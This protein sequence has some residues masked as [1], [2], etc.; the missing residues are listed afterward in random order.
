MKKEQKKGIDIFIFE[1]LCWIP[2]TNI[3][4]WINAVAQSLSRFRLFATPW[5]IQSLEFSRP[6]YWSGEPCPQGSS[7]PR[8]RTQVSH[9]A[10]G[11]FTSW[12]QGSPINQL[13]FNLKKSTGNTWLISLPH[14]ASP[15]VSAPVVLER[16]LVV[17]EVFCSLGP[18]VARCPETE[19]RGPCITLKQGHSS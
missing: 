9:I 18:V 12:D 8:D 3:T 19:V 14:D 11:F 15:A 16:P 1:S 5:T 13:D 10:G 2:E 17:T 4:L 6:E 7:Q